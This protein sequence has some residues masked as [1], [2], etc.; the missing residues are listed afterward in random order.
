MDLAAIANS[1]R[2][3]KM[4]MNN[5]ANPKKDTNSEAWANRIIIEGEKD[6]RKQP[7]KDTLGSTVD[8]TMRSDNKD[9]VD[10]HS[11]MEVKSASG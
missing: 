6:G 3:P 11:F 10:G 8:N 2:T 1:F 4:P 5:S 9:E 7:W